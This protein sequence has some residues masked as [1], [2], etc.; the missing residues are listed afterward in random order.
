MYVFHSTAPVLAF[1]A[2]SYPSHE[3]KYATPPVTIGAGTIGPPALN[4]HSGLSAWAAAGETVVSLDAFV[5][6]RS[7]IGIDQSSLVAAA[8]L[9]DA[10][11]VARAGA[12]ISPATPTAIAALDASD[13]PTTRRTRR[14]RLSA[15]SLSLSPVTATPEATTYW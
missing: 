12:A 11:E 8:L 10:R 5:R 3:E 13:S 2:Y 15:T 4:V 14:R 6:D 1:N 7:C 9:A